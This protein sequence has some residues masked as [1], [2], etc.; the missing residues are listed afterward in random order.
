LRRDVGFE[1][2]SPGAVGRGEEVFRD[3]FGGGGVGL[4]VGG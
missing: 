1:G 3:G 2:L 4:A